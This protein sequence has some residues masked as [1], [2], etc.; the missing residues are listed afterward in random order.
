MS[1]N[2]NYIHMCSIQKKVK[3]QSRFE[4][5]ELFNNYMKC[6][7]LMLKIFKNSLE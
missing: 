5:N 3:S 4:I 1:I 7:E 6:I 2:S